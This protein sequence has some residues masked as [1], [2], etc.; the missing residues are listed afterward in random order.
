[1]PACL[2]DIGVYLY[3]NLRMLKKQ[4]GGAFITL[5]KIETMEEAEFFADVFT[6]AEM[7]LGFEPLSAIK[8]S[9]VVE[10]IQGLVQLDEMI[11]SLRHYIVSVNTG[12]WGYIFD[13][14][15]SFRHERKHLVPMP[16]RNDLS[17]YTNYMQAYAKRIIHV[18][19]KR[20]V[21]ALGG[22]PT[23]IP[24]KGQTDITQIAL[25]RVKA[26]IFRDA[27]LGYDGS[28]VAHPGLVKT[29]SQVY[30]SI[31]RNNYN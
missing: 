6:A 13:I 19:H 9:L 11:Y 28:W 4:Q 24:R 14:I 10:S 16:A 21:L 15:K 27:K 22:V 12:Q 8:C 25:K 18:A 26:D 31:I 17:M 7:Y 5:P 29:A 3:H 2:F 20:G 1:M 23:H 30:N